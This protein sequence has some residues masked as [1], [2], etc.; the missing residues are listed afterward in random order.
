M[1][2]S[3]FFIFFVFSTLALANNFEFKDE[4]RM[5]SGAMYS[6]EVRESAYKANPLGYPDGRGMWG[7]DG[8]IPH[9]RIDIL[10]VKIDGEDVLLPHKYFSDLCNISKVVVF[11]AE[12]NLKISIKGGDAAGSFTAEYL[13]SN[14]TLQE[15]IVRLG[16]FPDEVWEKIIFH[17]T[18]WNDPDM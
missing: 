1:K 2:S 9:S 12:G 5:K 10:K 4:G 18:I 8:G 15:R 11:E 7:I 13:I 16:E 3:I 14:H 6:V 17:N